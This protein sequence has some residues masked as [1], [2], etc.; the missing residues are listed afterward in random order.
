ML[1]GW[2]GRSHYEYVSCLSFAETL[3]NHLEPEPEPLRRGDLLNSINKLAGERAQ[4]AKQHHLLQ[5][6][7]AIMVQ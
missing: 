7:P 6:P 2:H 5:R 1:A 3:I 4:L